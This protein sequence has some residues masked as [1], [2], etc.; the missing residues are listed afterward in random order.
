MAIQSDP[1]CKITQINELISAVYGK[2]IS[3]HI[4]DRWRRLPS[5]VNADASPVPVERSQCTPSN[6]AVAQ[7]AIASSRR[8]EYAVTAA[9]SIC[10]PIAPKEKGG[11]R[12]CS[13]GAGPACDA[14]LAHA[15]ATFPP[16]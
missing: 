13:G 4:R 6:P 1:I 8:L 7:I 10:E 15:S 5:D 14:R 11:S 12:E 16:R 9:Q 2:Q 3:H